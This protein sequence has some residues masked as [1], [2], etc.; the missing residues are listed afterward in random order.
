MMSS[1][2]IDI[3]NGFSKTI[4][5]FNSLFKGIVFY[6]LFNI[7]EISNALHEIWHYV[8]CVVLFFDGILQARPLKN[9]ANGVQEKNH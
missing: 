5:I 6:I 2:T 7:I 1:K 3:C 8:S 4:N 9:H